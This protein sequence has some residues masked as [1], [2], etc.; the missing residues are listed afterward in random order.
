MGDY[1]VEEEMS[2]FDSEME[3]ESGSIE[4]TGQESMSYGKQEQ[5]II[6]LYLVR[7]RMQEKGWDQK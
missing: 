4:M 1:P 5:R 3:L 7:F 2:D 6:L